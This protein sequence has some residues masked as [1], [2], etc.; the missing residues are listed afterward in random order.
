MFRFGTFVEIGEILKDVI[1]AFNKPPQASPIQPKPAQASPSQHTPVLISKKKMKKFFFRKKK[2][3]LKK[4][5][6]FRETNL[7]ST[8]SLEHVP[9]SAGYYTDEIFLFH[10]T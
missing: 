9:V 3:V 4:F 8:R 10:V 6:K 1:A 5:Q 7:K 2:N